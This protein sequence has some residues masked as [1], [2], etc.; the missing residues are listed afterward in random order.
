M[1]YV[2]NFFQEYIS[3][4]FDGYGLLFC[5]TAVILLFLLFNCIIIKLHAA[6]N[7]T[8]RKK[9]L[10][11]VKTLKQLKLPAIICRHV[12]FYYYTQDSCV[13]MLLNTWSMG[14]NYSI[15]VL[16]SSMNT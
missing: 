15:L 9:I 10:F 7:G 14:S 12:V 2:T 5:F 1:H 4:Y 13:S 6:N 16:A 8:L 11:L 3:S